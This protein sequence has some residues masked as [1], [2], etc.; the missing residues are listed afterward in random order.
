MTD[1]TKLLVGL[2]KQK[3]G[4]LEKAIDLYTPYVSV[5]VYN[6]I[7]RAMTKEDAEEVVSDIFISLW[8]CASSLDLKKGNLRAY[9]GT[10]ARNAAKKKLRTALAAADELDENIP[11]CTVSPE[12]KAEKNEELAMLLALI[13]GLGEPDSEIFL[14]HYWYGENVSKISQATGI[15][16]STVTTKLHRGRKKLKKILTKEV[17]Q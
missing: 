8:R 16:K 17:W 14:R 6:V 4:S 12:E 15:C 10:I 3:R 2:K 13:D 7:G 1:D 11:S 5:I 9:L